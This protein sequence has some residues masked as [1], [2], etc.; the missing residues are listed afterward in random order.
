MWCK[1]EEEKDDRGP[2]GNVGI[3]GNNGSDG[4]G[5]W[6]EMVWVCVEEDDRHVLRKVFEFEVKGKRKQG[7]PKK[8]WKI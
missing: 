3:E 8:R 6:N 7:R 5:E 2:N 1:T 4:K